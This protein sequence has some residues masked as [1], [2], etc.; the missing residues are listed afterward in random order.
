MD[1]I[2]PNYVVGMIYGCLVEA[3]ASEH[4]ARMTAMQS[5]TDSAGYYQR[6]FYCYITVQD[7]LQLLRK[8]LRL[9]QERKAQKRKRK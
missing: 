8:L 9:L 3:Y 1:I 7:R 2:V 6:S 5:A 4:N